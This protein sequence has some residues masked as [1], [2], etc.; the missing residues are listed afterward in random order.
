M[1]DKIKSLYQKIIDRGEEYYHNKNDYIEYNEDYTESEDRKHIW[2]IKSADDFTDMPCNLVTKNDLDIVYLKNKKK[3]VIGVETIYGFVDSYEGEK[4]YLKHLLVKF[5]DWM[6]ENNYS[7]TKPLRLWQ[8]GE[9]TL[10]TEF[11]TIED[12][13]AAFKHM[14]EGF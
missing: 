13:Y 1:N 5:T 2:G 11:D 6:K 7:T 10:H 8:F 3:Y 4:N 12:V 14:V 9:I